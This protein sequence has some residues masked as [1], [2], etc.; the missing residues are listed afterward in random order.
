MKNWITV[1]LGA[2]IIVWFL[3]GLGHGIL[4]LFIRWQSLGWMYPF[5][6]WLMC[7]S[8]EMQS[9]VNAE[10]K[11]WPWRGIISGVLDDESAQ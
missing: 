1:R 2:F 8:S 3:F 4:R 10:G 9:V 11:W 5:H 7:A 6:N